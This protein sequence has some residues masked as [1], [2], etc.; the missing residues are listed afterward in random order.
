MARIPGSEQAI[1]LMVNCKT[2]PAVSS[3]YVETV[4]TGGVQPNGEFV[5]LYTQCRFGF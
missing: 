2:Y 1:E 4:C 5:R 3:K